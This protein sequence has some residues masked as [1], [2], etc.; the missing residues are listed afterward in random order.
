MIFLSDSLLV[1]RFGGSSHGCHPPQIPIDVSKTQTVCEC[2]DGNREESGHFGVLQRYAPQL[3]KAA[4][5]YAKLRWFNYLGLRSIT[6]AFCLFSTTYN[7]T[8]KLIIRWF[9][10][11]VLVGPPLKQFQL[12]SAPACAG[13][14]P[15]IGGPA[16]VLNFGFLKRI[17]SDIPLNWNVEDDEG[18]VIEHSREEL[19]RFRDKQKA[20]L[21]WAKQHGL[22]VLKK[23]VQCSKFQ[24]HFDAQMDCSGP[25]AQSLTTC[26][27]QCQEVQI[28]EWDLSSGTLPER[29]P[30]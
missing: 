16:A 19:Q 30:E 10:V 9:Q 22:E 4:L 26:C 28:A 12:S 23:T 25:Y 6:H 27:P 18:P 20:D 2:Q 3:F 5:L 8:R 17:P 11:Q 24:H 13:G 21:A 15:A 29:P 14:T 1:D 7:D